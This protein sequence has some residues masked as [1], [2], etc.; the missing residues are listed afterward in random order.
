MEQNAR[1]LV[2]C[3]G[4][5][6]AISSAVRR[7]LRALPGVTQIAK[8]AQLMIRRNEILP[9]RL[10]NAAKSRS[11]RQARGKIP[12]D[13]GSA[14]GGKEKRTGHRKH[15]LLPK[16]VDCVEFLRLWKK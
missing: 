12:L 1:A 14:L 11:E 7:D 3:Y 2:L 8:I 4:E 10:A 9:A 13:F 15:I 16:P 5:A 6:H